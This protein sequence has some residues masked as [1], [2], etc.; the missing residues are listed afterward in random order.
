MT[1]YDP[2]F[3]PNK[4]PV[5]GEDG[6]G[7]KRLSSISGFALVC[8]LRRVLDERCGKNKQNHI[9]KFLVGGGKNRGGKCR[10]MSCRWIAQQMLA[11]MG[12]EEAIQNPIIR[13]DDWVEI[14]P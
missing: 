11:E 3:H 14:R 8:T 10:E 1:I 9:S 6:T 7:P 4:P 13:E 2:A 12:W 5:Y